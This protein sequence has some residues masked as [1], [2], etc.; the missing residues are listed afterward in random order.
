[1]TPSL[2][3][4]KWID[5]PRRADQRGTLTIVGHDD[6]PFSIARIFYVHHVPPGLERGGHAHRVTEQFLIAVSGAFSLDLTDG[7]ETRSYRLDHPDRGI[8]IPPM[9]WDRLYDFTP[10]AICL[11]LAST[12][13]AESDYVRK[14]DD[15]RRLVSEGA[16]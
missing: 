13:Y 1:M 6:I 9:V 15:F 7:K 11:V 8:Y 10:E 2:H 5:L 3:A 4:I 14:W 12:Q 16:A